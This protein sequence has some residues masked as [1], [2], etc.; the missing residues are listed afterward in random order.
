ME[1]VGDKS[2]NPFENSVNDIP[3]TSICRTIEIDSREMLG[4]KNIP[5]KVYP[6]NKIIM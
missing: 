2:E 1:V 3:M 6:V 5:G 4:E